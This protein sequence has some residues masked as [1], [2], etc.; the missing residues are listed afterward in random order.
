MRQVFKVDSFDEST[1]FSQELEAAVQKLPFEALSMPRSLGRRL[2]R[3][4]VRERFDS[5]YDE[6]HSTISAILTA[7]VKMIPAMTRDAHNKSLSTLTGGAWESFLQTLDWQVQSAR[8][9][10][11]PDCVVLAREKSQDFMPFLLA[12][13]KDVE[14]VVLPLAH[15]R[16]LLG[17]REPGS[18]PTLETLNA[19]SAACSDNFFISSSEA[20]GAG[21]AH[22][23]GQRS[24]TFIESSVSDA[25]S[26]F[27]P[28]GE[29]NTNLGPREPTPAS[30]HV[31]NALSFSLTCV[32]FESTDTAAALGEIVH[33]VVHELNRNM[34]LLSLDGIVFAEDYAAA[35]RNVDRGDP[36]LGT[37]SAQSREYG[38]GVAKPVKVVRSGV[39][40]TVSVRSG[41]SLEVAQGN[42]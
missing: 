40:K 36:S 35:V 25:L 39:P 8:G 10:L 37:D 41:H 14:L 27:R 7:L 18:A 32:G 13:R 28:Q 6:N 9:A 5:M 4:F 3:F 1:L 26:T 33:A 42:A 23:I 24:A 15:D 22:L 38:R 17:F 11:L 31:A 29:S 34:P 16:L 12:E 30:N 19:A 2:A 21:L 20:D